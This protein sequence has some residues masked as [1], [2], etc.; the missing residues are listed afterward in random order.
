MLHPTLCGFRPEGTLTS[1]F[2]LTY[3]LSEGGLYTSTLDAPSRGERLWVELAPPGHDKAVHLRGE[4]VW[5]QRLSNR[6]GS[7]PGF[8]LRFLPRRVRDE[9]PGCLHSRVPDAGR[10]TSSRPHL[11]LAVATATIR[12]V[13]PRGVLRRT[14]WTVVAFIALAA[15]VYTTLGLTRFWTFHNVT[16]DLAFYGRMAWGMAHGEFWDPIVNGHFLG[17]HLCVVLLPF[18][19]LGI[20]GG[21]PE[22]LL[23]A[24]ALT[25]AGA[26]WPLVAHGV[27][28]RRRVGSAVGERGVPAVPHG[29]SRC[30]L[31]VSS[32]LD[33]RPSDRV[34]PGCAWMTVAHET[35]C[36]RASRSSLAAKTSRL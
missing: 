25:L 10:V 19:V 34:A 22:L 35:S 1:S 21:L 3:N 29:K 26:A 17:L 32:R 20:F 16:F 11:A 27:A 30:F 7:P 8:G 15:F 24:Q 23:I 31:R 5:G 33:G 6:R 12:N 18:G 4:V 14:R 2:G 13:R 28:A 36:G 9:R